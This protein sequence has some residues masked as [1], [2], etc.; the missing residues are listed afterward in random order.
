MTHQEC[1]YASAVDIDVPCN[2]HD[3]PKRA[4][5][6]PSGPGGTH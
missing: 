1:E 4:T 6:E 2:T 3:D 5:K